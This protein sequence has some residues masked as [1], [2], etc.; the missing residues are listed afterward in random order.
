[1]AGLVPAIP[2]LEIRCPPKRDRGDKPGDDMPR[3]SRERLIPPRGLVRTLAYNA[4][5]A[6]RR[7]APPKSAPCGAGAPIACRS[8]GH[9][10]LHRGS[11]QGPMAR[12]RWL[13]PGP[14]FREMACLRKPARP[15]SS[16]QC[17][18]SAA[19]AGFRG[20][21]S[22]RLRAAP[23]DLGL[24]RDR[25]SKRASRVNP[26]CAGRTRSID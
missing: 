14:R 21:P 15:A 17:G 12:D 22:A 7:A 11:R 4:R 24:A 16:S 18:L 26:T 13:S 6:E 2:I 9:S 3:H 5:G 25:Q 8:A 10:A 23:I 1:M 19:R 20:R